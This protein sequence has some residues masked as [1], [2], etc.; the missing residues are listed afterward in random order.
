VFVHIKSFI[1]RQ[2]RP[3]GNEI[4]TYELKTDARGRPQAGSVAYAGERL[5]SA[6]SMRLSNVILLSTIVF[7]CFVAGEA[8]AGRLPFF[9]PALYLLVSSVAFAVYAFDKAAARQERWR[10][11]E[12]TLHLLALIG[13]WPGALVAQRLLRHKCRKRAFQTVFWATVAIN[14]VALG[15]LLSSPEPVAALGAMIGVGEPNL[16]LK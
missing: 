1:N 2:R 6:T 13:G 5:P 15:W 14:G 16:F 8:V 12:S 10:T 3:I 11:R 4:V 9:V 7:L